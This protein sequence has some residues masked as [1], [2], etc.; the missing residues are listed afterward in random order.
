MTEVL[1][2]KMKKKIMKDLVNIEILANDINSNEIAEATRQLWLVVK[3]LTGEE[4]PTEPPNYGLDY[5][6]EHLKF[7]MVKFQNETWN[8]S[9]HEGVEVQEDDVIQAWRAAAHETGYFK[10]EKE[11]ESYDFREAQKALDEGFKVYVAH[12]DKK[13]EQV[14]SRFEIKDAIGHLFV[15]KEA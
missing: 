3:D 8:G 9:F 14:H 6:A 13:D 4:A 1:D 7:A 10:Q 11:T 5:D 12:P 2:Y 15:W